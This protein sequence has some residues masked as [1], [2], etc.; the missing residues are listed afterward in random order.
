[1]TS[2]LPGLDS[3]VSFDSLQAIDVTQVIDFLALKGGLKQPGR[4]KGVSGMTTK[5]KLPN[6]SVGDALEVVL[7][8][9]NLA[10]E[11][12]RRHH[13]D[14]HRCRVQGHVRDQLSTT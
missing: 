6:I 7:S 1:V 11:S 13:L 12:Q 10:Y 3:K 2:N 9:N 5:L 14:H 4:R 8:M